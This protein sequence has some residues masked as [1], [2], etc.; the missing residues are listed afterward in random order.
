MDMC[1]ATAAI[2]SGY[3]GGGVL[4]KAKEME[5]GRGIYLARVDFLTAEGVIVGTHV[6]GRCWKY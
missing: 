6:G 3:R 2:P 5:R 1:N 4:E